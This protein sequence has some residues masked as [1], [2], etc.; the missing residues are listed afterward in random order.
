MT[1]NLPP[2]SA[3]RVFEAAARHLNFTRAADELAMTQAAVSY[4]IKVLEDR[5]GGPLFER[6]PRG[7]TLTARG[8]RFQRGAAD[9]LALLS[10]AFAAARDQGQETL[11]IS[12]APTFAS[13]YLARRLGAFQIAHPS[14]AV[15][16][17]VD[18]GLTD[19][20][21]T[22][23]AV[24]H[25]AGDWPGMR[26]D[27]LLDA[28]ASPMLTPELAETIGGV[29]APEDL[30]RLPRLEADDPWWRGWFGAVGVEAPA[31]EDGRAVTFGAQ[32]LEASAALAGHGVGR[33][34]PFLFREALRQGRLLQPFS[35]THGDAAAFWLVSPEGRS[36]IPKIRAFREWLL[37]ELRA[38][39][40]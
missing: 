8:L 39:V 23:L 28:A 30:L 2:M 14:L 5:I 20:A 25:G 9:A 19:F 29:H 37:T 40:E 11:S 18:Q 26:A 27:L 17:I 36:D 3:V 35:R 15:R 21:T 12:V 22:D 6:G 24:R 7:V 10:D 4:Q 34:T 1:R 38:D 32:S 33:L 16:V 31:R 13:E